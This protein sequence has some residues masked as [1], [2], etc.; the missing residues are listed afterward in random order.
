MLRVR[1]STKTAS[2]SVSR[3]G[4]TCRFLMGSAAYS[5]KT[6]SLPA[7]PRADLSGQCF[8]MP[9][10]QY[11]HVPQPQLISPTTRLPTRSGRAGPVRSTTPINSWPGTP[12]K[13]LYPFRAIPCP[14]RRCPPSLPA[15]GPRPAA[16]AAGLHG[17]RASVSH[18]KK[19]PSYEVYVITAP[20][21]PQAKKPRIIDALPFSFVI[22]AFKGRKSRATGKK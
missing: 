12:R 3:S 17:N 5:A 19:A 21:G 9:P 4:T 2:S 15:Q 16:L 22:I 7:I 8:S 14:S 1:G 11:A 20:F 13:P 18:R 10:R 6:P